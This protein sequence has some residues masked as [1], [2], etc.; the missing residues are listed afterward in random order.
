MGKKSGAAWD[1]RRASPL[2]NYFK[3]SCH[4]GENRLGAH[5]RVHR[6]DWK[7]I[8]LGWSDSP[9]RFRNRQ[10]KKRGHQN[11]FELSSDPYHPYQNTRNEGYE[12][13]PRGIW[14]SVWNLVSCSSHSILGLKPCIRNDVATTRSPRDACGLEWICGPFSNGSVIQIWSR[15]CDIWSH[16]GVS[17]YGIRWT[18][19][20]LSVSGR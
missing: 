16:R 14:S 5:T 19:F 4:S 13:G 2:V 1:L 11:Q 7:Q 6:R 18:R 3:V 8:G 9:R 20:S 12:S 17:M 15:Q 10:V